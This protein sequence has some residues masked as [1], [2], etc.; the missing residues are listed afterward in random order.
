MYNENESELKNT[1]NGLIYNYNELLIDEKLDFRKED[2]TIFLICDGF[3]RI[4][5]SFKQYATEK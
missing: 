5:E 2:F 3:D 4:P 1:L